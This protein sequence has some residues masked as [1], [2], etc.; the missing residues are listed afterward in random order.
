MGYGKEAYL[1]LSLPLYTVVL[2][3]LLP[4]GGPSRPPPPPLCG[5]SPSQDQSQL[6]S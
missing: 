5:E 3:Y 1:Y 2:Q 6:R 4:L